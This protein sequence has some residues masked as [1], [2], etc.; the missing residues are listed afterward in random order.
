M[1]DFVHLHTH[2]SYSHDGISSID[3]LLQKVKDNK[4]SSIAITD[5]GTLAALPELAGLS[6]DYGIKPIAGEEIYL[7]VDGQITHLTLLASGLKG[8]N[9]LVNI[10]NAG[11]YR[12]LQTGVNINRHPSTF[13]DLIKYNEGITVL[14]GCPASY[15]QYNYAPYQEALKQWT[16]LKKY[17]SGRMFVEV[18]LHAKENNLET[19][20]RKSHINDDDLQTVDYGKSL[21]RSIRLSRDSNIPMVVTNDSHFINKEDA[22]AHKV[23]NSV[24]R[25]HSYPNRDLYLMTEDE[26]LNNVNELVSPRHKVIRKKLKQAVS[27]TKEVADKLEELKFDATPALP[28]IE[29]ADERFK[30]IVERAFN[31]YQFDTQE[32]KD[33]FRKT[34]DEEMELY[35]RK[36]FST[37][38]LIQKEMIDYVINQGGIVGGRGSVVG[39]V[40]AHLLGI[41]ESNPYKAGLLS[42]RF[43]SEDRD[44]YPDIDEDYPKLYRDMLIEYMTSKYNAIGISTNSVYSK[45]S[46]DEDGSKLLHRDLLKYA[47]YMGFNK[48]HINSI[49]D[50][51]KDSPHYDELIQTFPEYD[52]VFETLS[53]DVIRHAG[54]HAAGIVI[55]PDSK[56]NFPLKISDG[57]LLCEFSEGTHGSFLS[58]VGGVKYDILGLDA[59][60][61]IY[62]MRERTQDYFIDKFDYNKW[63]DFYSIFEHDKDLMGIFQF[64]GYPMRKLIQ[65]NGFYPKSFRDLVMLTSIVRTGARESGTQ[66]EYIN[67]RP[68]SGLYF[69]KLATEKDGILVDIEYNNETYTVYDN[70]Q[71]QL[72]NGNFK[73]ISDIT[74]E[75]LKVY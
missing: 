63:Y 71:V 2:S 34:V 16:F 61:L 33:Y 70:W 53:D 68:I 27:R 25:G 48:N 66:E 3:T 67:N 54:K 55:I 46:D 43:L 50:M 69:R 52:S 28:H 11:V 65:D 8:Y 24:V 14:S 4:Q 58:K 36:G 5:H 1:C 13:D 64:S 10:H 32:E 42:E 23:F 39:S 41:S 15:F 20:I 37:F 9:N 74:S 7:E 31:N 29:N 40:V 12:A 21:L 56:Y 35:L 51:Y 22:L 73:K 72:E 6:K 19:N 18:M 75:K 45:T 60:Q 47:N 49:V 57:R 38:F 30:E 59:L 17:F 26:I 44:A 62:N